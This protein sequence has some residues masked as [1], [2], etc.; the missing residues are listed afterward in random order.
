MLDLALR[1][2]L[3]L[4]LVLAISA[5]ILIWLL[6]KDKIHIEYALLWFFALLLGVAIASSNRFLMFLTRL[7][8]A[9][10]PASA[11]AYLGF[12]F[13]FFVLIYFSTRIS[14]LS[15]KL[16]SLTQYVALLEKELKDSPPAP[17]SDEAPAP[18]DDHPPP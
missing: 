13:I 1:S 10:I 17:R 6:L 2:Q 12:A 4:V 11:L 15:N 9:K 18:S 16:K 14:V 7:I 3:A 5:V 8:G